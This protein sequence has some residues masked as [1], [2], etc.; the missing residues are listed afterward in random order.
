MPK[1]DTKLTKS[2]GEHFVCSQLARIGWASSLTRDGLERTDVLAVY[3]RALASDARPIAEIQ[4]KALRVAGSWLLGKKGTLA[5][6]GSREWYILVVLGSE[7]EAQPRAW[8]V[9][10]DHVAAATWIAHTSWL[11]SPEVPPRKRNAGIE[12][13]RLSPAD[14]AAYESRWDLLLTKTADAP[15]LLGRWMRDAA[16][17]P[18]VGL[19]PDH[20]WIKRLPKWSPN[21]PD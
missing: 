17:D 9:P 6:L 19:P 14:F 15:V 4:V 16:K 13:A 8:I 18:A 2:A 7:L 5:S 12:A 3:T 11:N 21:A 20:P 10:R 1:T